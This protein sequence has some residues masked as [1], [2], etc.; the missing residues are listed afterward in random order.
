MKCDNCG[1]FVV[2][3]EVCLSKFIQLIRKLTNTPQLLPFF[4][5]EHRKMLQQFPDCFL[6]LL[7]SR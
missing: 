5:A 2:T 1:K 3:F 4:P 6:G 7:L